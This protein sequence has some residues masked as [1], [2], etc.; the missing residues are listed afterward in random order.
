MTTSRVI[1]LRTVHCITVLTRCVIKYTQGTHLEH[2]ASPIR[3][4]RARLFSNYCVLSESN[5]FSQFTDYRVTL[6]HLGQIRFFFHWTKRQ[7]MYQ[8]HSRGCLSHSGQTIIIIFHTDQTCPVQK[9]LVSHGR[10]MCVHC[11]TRPNSTFHLEL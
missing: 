4:F 7:Y 9:Y 1:L 3:T 5:T 6:L 10:V 8:V 2:D 11:C